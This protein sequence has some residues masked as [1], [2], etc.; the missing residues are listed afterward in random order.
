MRCGV[1]Q[2]LRLLHIKFIG[3]VR[4]V[5]VCESARVQ[6]DRIHMCYT[7]LSSVGGGIRALFV[8]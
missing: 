5:R 7:A 1:V 4:N 6:P 3:F 2:R 8:N